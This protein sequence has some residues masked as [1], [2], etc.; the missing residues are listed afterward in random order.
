MLIELAN[1]QALPEKN[2]VISAI[3]IGNLPLQGIKLFVTVAISL[4]LGDSIMRQPVT[5]QALQPIPIAIVRPCLPC[6][7]HF[8]K[9]LSR[10]NAVN[11]QSP[12]SA[13]TAE[14]I[15]PLAAALPQPPN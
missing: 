11:S 8:E 14:K 1:T 4:S 2:I 10:L 6:A 3:S 12:L 15:S 9:N 13:Q 7:P 5:P